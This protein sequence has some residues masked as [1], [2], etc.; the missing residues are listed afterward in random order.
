MVVNR[1]S[2]ID[3]YILVQNLKT[4]VVNISFFRYQSVENNKSEPTVKGVWRR[5]KNK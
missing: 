5:T 3:N 1:I 2:P 4:R